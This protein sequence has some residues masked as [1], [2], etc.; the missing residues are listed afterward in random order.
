V[1]T[2]KE[3]ISFIN[4]LEAFANSNAMRFLYFGLIGI[5]ILSHIRY[6]YL[7]L[8]KKPTSGN[9]FLDIWDGIWWL[10]NGLYLSDFGQHEHRFHQF[11]SLVMIIVTQFQGMVTAD[12]TLA[13]IKSSITSIDDLKQRETGVVKGTTAEKFA[14]DNNLTTKTYDTSNDM[15]NDIE[16]S[17]LGVAIADSPIINYY[18]SQNG[19]NKA[20]ESIVL[21]IEHYAIAMPLNSKYRKEINQ[22]I[23]EI[24]QDGTMARLNTKW[25]GE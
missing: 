10:F 14:L 18:I 21:N 17:D 4:Q 15:F 2:Q 7:V 1:I 23:L 3:K 9:Y 6:V 8:L 24:E 19:N 20:Q 13:Q 12:L 11:V 25:F 5:L 22:A 16:S